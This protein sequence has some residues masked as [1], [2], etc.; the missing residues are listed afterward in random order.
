MKNR[1]IGFEFGIFAIAMFVYYITAAPS[2]MFTDSGELAAACSSLNIAHPTGYP[3]FTILGHLW[4]VIN[5]MNS[6]IAWLNIFAGVYT[7]FSAVF[8]MKWVRIFIDCGKKVEGFSYNA[9]TMLSAGIALAYA[10]SQTV[11]QQAVQIEVYSL[12]LLLI[13]MILFF[14][15]KGLTCEKERK[16]FLLTAL[17]IGFGFANHGT[18]ILLLPAILLLFFKR[19][20]EKFDFSKTRFIQ[21]L[22]LFIPI[23]I[24]AA[25]YLYLPIRSSMTPDINWGEVH[26]SWDKFLYH[27]GGKQYRVMMFTGMENFVGNFKLF[28]KLMP[29]QFNMLLPIAVPGVLYLLMNSKTKFW[30]IILM[31]LSCA[32][33]SF[34]YDIHDI[35]SYFLTGYIGIFVFG[36]FGVLGVLKKA[37]KLV[38]LIF[39]VPVLS[40]GLN[41]KTCDESNN[42]TVEAYTKMLLE[43]LEE[44]AVI[45][46]SQWDFWVS[47][48]W[49]LQTVENIRPDVVL[50]E[51]EL[52]RRTWYR[53]QMAA[54][55][56]K[57]FERV[58]NE[59][60]NYMI[61]LEKFESGKKY[62]A[63]KIQVRYEKLFSS[64]IAKN[65][66]ERPIY[67]TIDIMQRERSIGNGYVK[68][69]QGMAIRLTKSEK[70]VASKAT[71]ELEKQFLESIKG[72]EGHL[73][74]G[75]EGLY[76]NNKRILEQYRSMN[77]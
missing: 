34:N 16:Y 25:L 65:I 49:Y 6:D 20:N 45:I 41:H 59:Y 64:M 3:L 47:A 19:P 14:F 73:Y 22:T 44:D 2:L 4:T 1:K 10:F 18:T 21:L 17:F 46:S 13:N 40:L 35:D 12:Q 51:Q 52:V 5:P 31:L 39:L 30:F 26:R 36:I 43:N 38:P 76:Q 55:Y 27:A 60:D 29:A 75:I 72:R 7:A 37:P 53:N 69:P 62:D 57:F 11:W 61:E 70:P 68:H 67:M 9:K 32:A 71:P 8:L 24:G 33:Y 23:V 42:Y 66:D 15:M 48:F 28:F 58:A 77:K 63:R 54:Q 56:P 50:V 74:E